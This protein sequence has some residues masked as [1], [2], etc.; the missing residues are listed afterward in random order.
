MLVSCQ[1]FK[2]FVHLVARLQLSI[3][4]NGKATHR[5]PED[6]CHSRVLQKMHIYNPKG[7]LANP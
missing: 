6:V 3:R 7:T 1:F 2:L 5:M 4:S